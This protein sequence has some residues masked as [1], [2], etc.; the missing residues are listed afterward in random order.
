[1]QHLL[2]RYILDVMHFEINL[3]KNFLKTII[4]VKDIVKVRRD[5]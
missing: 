1:M 4:G 2:I 3:A 5:L